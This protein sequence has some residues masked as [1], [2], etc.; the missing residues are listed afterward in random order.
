MITFFYSLSLLFIWVELVQ[1]REKAVIYSPNFL[2]V[3]RTRL[4]IFLVSKII[5]FICLP[6]GLFTD[7]WFYFL[8]IICIELSKFLTPFTK[9]NMIINAYNLISVVV[10]IVIYLTIFIQ[11][12]VR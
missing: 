9:N 3:N 1:V 10:Y 6:L 4:T 8:M 5:N 2:E 7:L 11:G 12:V